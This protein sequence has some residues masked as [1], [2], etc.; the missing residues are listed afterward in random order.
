MAVS[1]SRVCRRRNLLSVGVSISHIH[2][3]P[4]AHEQTVEHPS[5]ERDTQDWPVCTCFK[6]RQEEYFS[7]EE[8]DAIKVMVGENSSELSGM[9]LSGTKNQLASKESQNS[10][11]TEELMGD[12][13]DHEQVSSNDELKPEI[14]I[15]SIEKVDIP[16]PKTYSTKSTSD[17]TPSSQ[18]ALNLA[19]NG[20]ASVGIGR[21][22]SVLMNDLNTIQLV[23]Q[24][25][26]SMKSITSIH[27]QSQKD[28]S[29]SVE[30]INENQ[31][32]VMLTVKKFN[33]R[34]DKQEQLLA[35]QDKS[36]AGPRE[37]S[38]ISID[39]QVPSTSHVQF[40]IKREY[41]LEK[42]NKWEYFWDKFSSELKSS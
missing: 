22:G 2:D 5:H 23:S 37:L 36:N 18:E 3:E 11:K 21:S 16:I 26:E 42:E 25:C 34:L 35:S 9:E 15:K 33:E 30:V 14:K 19:P 40:R 7:E 29:K 41:K 17:D 31:K 39:F 13:S 1:L 32:A 8:W 12:S 38:K 4:I 27:I 6:A 20:Q 10:E 28:F 24:S